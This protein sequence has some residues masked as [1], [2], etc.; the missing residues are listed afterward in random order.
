MKSIENSIM[1][2]TS[3]TVSSVIAFG[4]LLETLPNAH[5]CTQQSSRHPSR[6]HASDSEV[7]EARTSCA[8]EFDFVSAQFDGLDDFS[9]LFDRGVFDGTFPLLQ[10]QADVLAF[11]TFEENESLELDGWDNCGDDCKE[12]EIPKDWCVAAE[13]KGVMEYLGLTRVEPLC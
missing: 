13:T 2:L 6:L 8:S 12:C 10:E 7:N 3:C 4:P 1:L 9:L 5:C 11:E